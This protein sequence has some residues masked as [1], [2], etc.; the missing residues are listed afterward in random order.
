[1]PRAPAAPSFQ[2]DYISTEL[3]HLGS[4]EIFRIRTAC[5]ESIFQL[6]KRDRIEIISA[7]ETFA[8]NCELLSYNST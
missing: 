3:V 4:I 5:I 2:I 8:W 1:M 6:S 7:F